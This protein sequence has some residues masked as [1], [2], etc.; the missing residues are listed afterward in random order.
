M[1][2]DAARF[3]RSR[4]VV[5]ADS[6]E[7]GVLGFGSILGNAE[8]PTVTPLAAGAETRTLSLGAR[9]GLSGP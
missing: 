1:S 8:G 3:G 6:F 9:G 4:L 5:L 7:V 2:R